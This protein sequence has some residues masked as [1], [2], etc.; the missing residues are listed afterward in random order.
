MQ[1]QY[2]GYDIVVEKHNEATHIAKIYDPKDKGKLVKQ[3]SSMYG[4][5]SAMKGAKDRVFV[6]NMAKP[7][8]EW[9]SP[10]RRGL[11]L[12]KVLKNRIKNRIARKMRVHNLR[13][14]Y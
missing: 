8:V 2:E 3:I 4:E 5:L 11:A 7:P 14:G 10:Y 6:M 12:L 9:V 1:E 13:Y